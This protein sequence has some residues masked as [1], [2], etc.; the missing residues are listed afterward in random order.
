MIRKRYARADGTLIHAEVQ[1]SIMSSANFEE[2][3]LGTIFLV[4]DPKRRFG[5]EPLWREAKR[6]RSVGIVKADQMGE[7]LFADQGWLTILELYIA[8]CEGQAPFADQST[9]FPRD[10]Q[11]PRRLVV[12]RDAGQI[13]LENENPASAQLTSRGT[14]QV[15]TV[16]RAELTS[17]ATG[18]SRAALPS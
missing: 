16:L 13:D 1:V 5:V 11:F 6:L 17:R 15:E 3:T 8:E 14:A 9:G 2:L 18:A 10:E 7:D 12:L 4:D